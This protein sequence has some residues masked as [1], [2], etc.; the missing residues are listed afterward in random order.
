MSLIEEM[1]YLAYGVTDLDRAVEFFRDIC[2]LEVTERSNGVVFLTGDTR[3]HWVRLEQQ[4]EPGLIRLG[5]RAVSAAAINEIATRLDRLGVEHRRVEALAADRVR[6][7]L[8][9]RAPDGIEYEIFEQM[10]SL[11]ASPAPARGITCLLHAVVFVEDISLGRDFYHEALGLLVSDQIE[12]VV[13][14]LRAA[15]R[16]HHALALARGPAGNLDHIALLVDGVEDVLGFRSHAKLHGV[17]SGDVVKHVASSSVSVYLNDPGVG[18]GVEYANGHGQIDDD[19]YG[20]RLLKA[21]ASTA[22]AW[23]AGFPKRPPLEA[24]VTAG[25]SPAGPEDHAGPGPNVAGTAA[26]AASL[27]AAAER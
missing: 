12:D 21:S 16:Y 1:G 15:N 5:Y 13:V 8:R 7:A 20:G 18:I 2:Q 17:L 24:A 19:N 6:G 14:F 25:P 23:A 10:L 9:F 11:P 3:H 26:S 22:N 4:N 27:V